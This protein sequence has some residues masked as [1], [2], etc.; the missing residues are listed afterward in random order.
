MTPRELQE[1]EQAEKH[2]EKMFRILYQRQQQLA[3]Q[4]IFTPL[5][6]PGAP[7]P[8]PVFVIGAKG[9][10]K[11]YTNPTMSIINS[12]NPNTL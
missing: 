5:L 9:A 10:K 4:G 12:H 8:P 1:Y 6:S 2:Q 3:Q 11:G 7:P